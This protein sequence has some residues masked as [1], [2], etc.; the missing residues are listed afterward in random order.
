MR[1]PQF[2]RFLHDTLGNGVRVSNEAAIHFVC[3]DWRHIGD[4]I[5]VGREAYDTMLNLVVWNKSNAGQGSFYRS[6]HELIG[7][8]RTGGRLHRTQRGGGGWGV[9]TL[10]S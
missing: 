5:D 8:F 4:L 1:S 3:M 7:V 10:N 6:Q 2:R 9:D